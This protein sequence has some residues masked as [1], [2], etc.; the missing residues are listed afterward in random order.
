[1]VGLGEGNREDHLVDKPNEFKASW[2]VEDFKDYE[3][4]VA[5]FQ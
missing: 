3:E 2:N 5:I 4:G 1:M